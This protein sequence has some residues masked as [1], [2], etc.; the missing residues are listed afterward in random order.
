MSALDR[1]VLGSAHSRAVPASAATGSTISGSSVSRDTE[2]QARTSRGGGLRRSRLRVAIAGI[3]MLAVLTSTQ[4]LANAAQQAGPSTAPTLAGA[5]AVERGAARVQRP[6]E[7]AIPGVA[8]VATAVAAAPVSGVT[9][10]ITG[11]SPRSPYTRKPTAKISIGVQITNASGVDLTGLQ[12]QLDRGS[13]MTTEKAIDTAL[14]TPPGARDIDL[15]AMKVKGTVVAGEIRT[16]T[17]KVTLGSGGLCLGCGPEPG[18]IY[19]I[20]VSLRANGNELARAH[21]L[22]PVFK[23][24]PKPVQVSWL[25]PLIEGPHRALSAGVFTDDALATS[26]APGGRLDRA[27][28]VVERVHLKAAVTIVTD[29]ELLDSLVVMSHGYTVQVPHHRAHPGAGQAAASAWLR[30]LRAVAADTPITLTSYADPDIDALTRAGIA[31]P[32]TLDAD[33]AAHVRSALGRVPP[34]TLVWPDGDNLTSKSLDAV[35]SNGATSVVLDDT[36]LPGESWASGQADATPDALSPLPAATGTATAIVLDTRLES[37]VATLTA[38]HGDE[39][40]LPG[41]LA[42]LAVRAAHQP[43]HRHYVALAPRR[44]VDPDVALA[45]TAILTVATAAWAASLPLATALAT[46][47]PV[48]RGVLYPASDLLALD[49]AQTTTLRDVAA[50]VSTLRDCL[51]NDGARRLVGGYT[52]AL[53]R[54]TSSW[55]RGHRSEGQDYVNALRSQISQQEASIRIESRPNSTFT[56]GSTD[57]PII[58]RVQNLLPVAVSFR[59]KVEQVTGDSGFR[60]DKLPVQTL[61]PGDHRDVKIGAH[62]EKS[63]RFQIGVALTSPG[64][65][66][67]SRSVPFR[68]HSTAYGRA[69]LWITGSAFAVLLLA[70]ARRAVLRGQRL[71]RR[72]RRGPRPALPTSFPAPQ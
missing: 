72:R 66:P 37:T 29:P 63:G 23:V 40:S 51:D 19:P 1:A 26:V 21:T 27:L 11:F 47:E 9:V 31:L 45:S 53:A 8:A 14:V 4:P 68:I 50:R 65:T 62:V 64:G 6:A 10:A 15:P 38:R 55:W 17:L 48:D 58:L 20:D 60:V 33:V 54:G 61:Q 52:L 71:W 18:S 28:Q 70:L 32:V 24:T 39:R 34:S 69:A 22:L 49:P 56:L 16:E 30:R 59:L 7:E 13:P 3:A 5:G 41:L 42:R 35:V 12:L 57:A 67:L 46:V 44:Y 43:T 2:R 25:W 36:A